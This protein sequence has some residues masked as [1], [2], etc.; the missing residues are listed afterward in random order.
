MSYLPCV[1]AGCRVDGTSRVAGGAE[2]AWGRLWAQ[3][4]KLEPRKGAAGLFQSGERKGEPGIT[5]RVKHSATT[6]TDTHT[7]AHVGLNGSF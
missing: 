7:H 1:L 3:A 6:G 5:S 4:T 2:E